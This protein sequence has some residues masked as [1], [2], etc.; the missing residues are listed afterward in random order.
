V[1]AS[2]EPR[3]LSVIALVSLLGCYGTPS[4]AR[5]QAVTMAALERAAREASTGAA[6][7]L[8][9]AA[10][11]VPETLAPAAALQAAAARLGEL[12]EPARAELRE[13]PVPAALLW[14]GVVARE[15]RPV[16]VGPPERTQLEAMREEAQ[17][18]LAAERLGDQAGPPVEEVLLAEGELTAVREQ[19]VLAAPLVR[20]GR[21]GAV[22]PPRAQFRVPR[23]P[24]AMTG[25]ARPESQSSP[26]P[27]GSGS[28]DSI[29]LG[30]DG[31]LWFT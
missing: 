14:L 23:P 25:L 26:V 8:A 5:V 22:A 20:R 7:Q 2:F 9:R 1:E 10:R 24:T 30:A 28:M 11:R 17:R 16:A 31:A 27:T 6:D 4:K 13:V 19:L 12:L 15:P 21:A 18:V 29:A 3:R